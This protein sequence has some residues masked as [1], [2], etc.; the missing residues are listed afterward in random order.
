MWIALGILMLLVIPGC[1]RT[2]TPSAR[3]GAASPCPQV[4]KGDGERPVLGIHHVPSLTQERYEAVVRELTGGHERL[5]SLSDGNIEGLVVHVAAQGDDGFWIVDV[6]ASQQ[7]VDR[8][9]QRVRPIAQNAGIEEP[10]KT[11]PI[12]TFLSC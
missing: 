9:G 7:A 4:R 6:W 1:Q 12:Q 3:G 8:F 11:Y 10:M 2:E 5:Q